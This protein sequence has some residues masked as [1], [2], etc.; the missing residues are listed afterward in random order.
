MS[1]N[2]QPKLDPPEPDL[3]RSSFES[4]LLPIW[5]MDPNLRLL[6]A[7]D[8]F[9][10]MLGRSRQELVGVAYPELV[11][12]DERD[13]HTT[14]LAAVLA[15]SEQSALRET[16]LLRADSLEVLVAVAVTAVKAQ[17]GSLHHLV[18]QAFDLTAQRQHEQ[19][20]RHMAD[21]DP[22][23]GV[24]NRRGFDRVLRRH[25]SRTT[26]L[27][28]DGALLMVDLDNFK[29]FNDEHG[30]AAGD[31]LLRRAA[32]AL[33]GRLRSEDTVGRLGGDEFAVLLPHSNPEQ[34]ATVADALVK[35]VAA[36]GDG[37][38]TITASIGVFCFENSGQ[39]PQSSALVGA[40]SAMYA[41]KNAGR[42]RYA[43]Y[44]AA[45]AT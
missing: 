40:D 38:Q 33:T 13:A 14:T 27:G 3:F 28:G 37:D 18:G 1:D 36:S 29:D 42:N 11:H 41:A 9:A 20:L 22:L 15:G 21:H 19:Q 16:C 45:S 5:I 23:T 7:N 43:P 34:A 10:V 44:V 26:A 8:A 35:A 17:D 25:I 39:A 12:T 32:A 30:H 4:A 31:E 2:D 6:A 24:L